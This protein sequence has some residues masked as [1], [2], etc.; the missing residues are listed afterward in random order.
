MGNSKGEAMTTSLADSSGAIIICQS[1]GV[2]CFV[3]SFVFWFGF[4]W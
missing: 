4:Q 2:G 1:G 3:H